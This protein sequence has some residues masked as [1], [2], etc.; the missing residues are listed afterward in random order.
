MERGKTYILK[1]ETMKKIVLLSLVCLV[2]VLLISCAGIRKSLPQT[3]ITGQDY[4]KLIFMGDECVAW[5]SPELKIIGQRDMAEYFKKNQ[6]KPKKSEI[7]EH[8]TSLGWMVDGSPKQDKY[9]TEYQLE[10]VK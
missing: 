2:S 5:F 3:K 6:V 8:F 1:G 10:R 7:L 9:T 4:A